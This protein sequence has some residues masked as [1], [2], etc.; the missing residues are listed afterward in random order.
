MSKDNCNFEML[1]MTSLSPSQKVMQNKKMK[2]RE[3]LEMGVISDLINSFQDGPTPT[4]PLGPV[5]ENCW[6][7]IG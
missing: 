4:N 7:I 6:I 1:G 3:Y 5:P 2:G